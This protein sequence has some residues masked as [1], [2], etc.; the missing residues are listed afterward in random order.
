MATP[1]PSVPLYGTNR[2]RMPSVS[3]AVQYQQRQA[4]SG[5]RLP[6][7]S[8]VSNLTPLSLHPHLSRGSDD[9]HCL[10]GLL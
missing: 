8:W 4:D 9:S 10:M 2:H 7:R 6:V 3:E 5:A 1:P